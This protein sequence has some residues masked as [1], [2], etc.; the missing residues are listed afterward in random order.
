M[1][2]VRMKIF[3]SYIK[4]PGMFAVVLGNGEGVKVSVLKKK[5]RMIA[6]HVPQTKVFTKVFKMLLILF[7]PV[8]DP[9]YLKFP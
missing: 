5:Y 6:A 1:I 4:V 7:V 9:T 3:A 2:K 8:P